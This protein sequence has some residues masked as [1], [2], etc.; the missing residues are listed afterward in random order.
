MRSELTLRPRGGAPDRPL[1]TVLIAF[2]APGQAR[3]AAL[4]EIGEELGYR[5]MRVAQYYSSGMILEEIVRSIRDAQLIIADLTRANP[6]VCYELGLAHALG[7]R[8]FLVAED[9]PSCPLEFGALRV[10]RFDATAAGRAYLRAELERFIATPGTLSPIDVFSGGLAV[11]GQ[12]LLGRRFCAFLVDLLI[13]APAAALLLA[14][15]AWAQQDAAAISIYVQSALG[16]AIACYFL[17]ASVVLTTTPGQ[18]IMGLE[19]TRLD[20]SAPS[21]AQRLLRPV[22][23]LLAFLTFGISF[24]WAARPP[25]HQAVHDIITRTLVLRSSGRGLFR[26]PNRKSAQPITFATQKNGGL[27]P[28]G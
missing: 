10:A 7:K 24:L 11:A 3:F 18:R 14:L 16:P 25:R 22:A 17:L 26:A 13:A 12:P 23:A 28:S 4:E 21:M 5:T 15:A 9:P 20:R 8:V 2:D 6:N 27:T 1:C 19:V